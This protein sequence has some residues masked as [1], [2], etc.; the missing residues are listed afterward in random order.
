[1]VIGAPLRETVAVS[2]TTGHRSYAEQT[3]HYFGRPHA[4]VPDTP[5][6]GPAAWRGEDLAATESWVH[7]LDPAHV[8]ELEAVARQVIDAGVALE[9]VTAADF[10]LPTLAAVIADWRDELVEGRGFVVV[11]GVPVDVWE[12]PVIETAYWLIGH[13][14]GVPGAQNPQ[15]DLLG[16]VHDTGEEATNPAIRRYR[17]SG[18]IDFHCDAA[19]VVGLLC[20]RPAK[21]G[22]QSRIASSV[23][24]FDEVLARR[25]DLVGRL[26]EPFPLDLRDEHAP[27]TSPVVPVSPCAHDGATLRTFWHSE[28]YR[29][30]PRHPEVPDYTADE[31]AL[32]DLYDSLAETPGVFLDM[33]LQ[34]GDMQFLSNHFVVHARTAYEDHGDPQLRRHLL[35]LWL[36]VEGA[37]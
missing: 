17:T 26:F 20:L 15:G 4:G 19:D 7:V 29:S 22:G 33:W 9:A 31:Q 28:Y 3:A 36:S 16:D 14:L 1:M 18:N 32:L 11:R 25:P 23:T 21:S 35:R 37:A 27:G 8:D 34:P 5:V 24:V 6:G 30:S 12:R 13:H 2:A 10:A